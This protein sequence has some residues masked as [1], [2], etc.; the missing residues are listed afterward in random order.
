MF[1]GCSRSK[2]TLISLD[3]NFIQRRTLSCHFNLINTII[4]QRGITMSMIRLAGKCQR[5][6]LLFVRSKGPLSGPALL[7]CSQ[8]KKSRAFSSGLNFNFQRS[9]RR[10]F[11]LFRVFFFFVVFVVVFIS[12]QPLEF[13][14]MQW[15]ILSS[16][17]HFIF[18]ICDNSL[19]KPRPRCFY[20]DCLVTYSK[21]IRICSIVCQSSFNSKQAPYGM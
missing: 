19:N 12:N 1:E 2:C 11:L 7:E 4:F 18:L 10:S 8:F 5:H 9:E 17:V 20:H 3:L 14:S 15:F 16:L 21:K 6:R 13:Q